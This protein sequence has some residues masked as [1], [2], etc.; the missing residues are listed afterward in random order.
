MQQITNNLNEIEE[1]SANFLDQYADIKFLWEEEL[2]VSFQ[3]FLSE[4]PDLRETFIERL[5]KVEE[6]VELEEE[7]I[8]EEIES[9]DAMSS[10]ILD[11]VTTRQPS[12][13]MFDE[14]ISQLHEVKARIADMKPSSDIG[15]LRVNSQPLINSLKQIVNQW[16]ERFTSFLLN[17]TTT[18]LK[19]INSFLTEVSEGIKELPPAALSA[20]KDKDKIN[21]N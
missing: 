21:L 16:I 15:W 5:H 13:E 17:N 19:N 8:E 4:G 2:E 3:K 20:E 1:A 6:G 18:Q 11:G 12:L 9:F 7:Q 10:K 14:K